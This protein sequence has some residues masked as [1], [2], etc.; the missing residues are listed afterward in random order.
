MSK[1]KAR[2]ATLAFCILFFGMLAELYDVMPESRLIILWVF[3]IP[4]AWKFVRVVFVWLTTED[5][6][7]EIKIPKWLHRKRKPKTYQEWAEANK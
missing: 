7:I 2:V 5:K 1:E 6:P 3:A 4:G